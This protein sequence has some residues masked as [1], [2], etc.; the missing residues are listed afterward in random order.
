MVNSQQRLTLLDESSLDSMS[1]YTHRKSGMHPTDESLKC[2]ET[3]MRSVADSMHFRILEF[4]GEADHVHVLLEFPP[5]LSVSVL[6]KHLKGVSSRAYNKAGYPKPADNALWSPSYFASSV[7]GAP[8]EV[9]QQ[10]IE[11]HAR[12][13]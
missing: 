10:Y 9:V 13:H 7:G 4:N 6:T 8:L 11:Q 2:I 12:P 3:S 1:N 5:K